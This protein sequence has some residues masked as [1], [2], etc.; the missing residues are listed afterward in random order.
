MVFLLK[1]RRFAPVRGRCL[2]LAGVLLAGLGLGFAAQ[3]QL[4]PRKVPLGE[5]LGGNINLCPHQQVTL[6]T[7]RNYEKGVMIE[8]QSGDYGIARATESDLNPSHLPYRREVVVIAGSN[9]TSASRYTTL[10]LKAVDTRRSPARSLGVL[11]EP[12]GSFNVTVLPEDS[13]TCLYHDP[14]RPFLQK[15]LE[16]PR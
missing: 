3:A 14:R 6:Y 15:R 1:P 9:P 11:Q 12:M 13:D 10:L 7:T 4:Y 8:A 16:I 2:V 5:L